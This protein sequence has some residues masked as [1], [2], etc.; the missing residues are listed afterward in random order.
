MVTGFRIQ[1][2][3]RLRPFTLVLETSASL[4]L[5][6]RAKPQNRCPIQALLARTCSHLELRPRARRI[7]VGHSHLLLPTMH[8]VNKVPKPKGVCPRP[9][10]DSRPIRAH[11]PCSVFSKLPHMTQVL[12]SIHI[13]CATNMCTPN[14]PR[15][16]P[17]SVASLSPCTHEAK[18]AP[19]IAEMCLKLVSGRAVF[20]PRPPPARGFPGGASGKEPTC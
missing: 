4:A 2:Q 3:W 18:E 17:V 8:R 11:S 9:V 20:S 16:V 7:L 15:H 14:N 5:L 10:Q 12:A 19:R 1:P 6:K 13:Y